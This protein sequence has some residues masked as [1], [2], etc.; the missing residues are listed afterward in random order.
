MAFV[1]S[2][3]LCHEVALHLAYR[4]FCKLDLDNRVP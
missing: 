4:W 2:A 1:M 3:G